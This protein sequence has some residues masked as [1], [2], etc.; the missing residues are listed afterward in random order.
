M[1]ESNKLFQNE[2]KINQS[3]NKR[4]KLIF[5]NNSN[6]KLKGSRGK[7]YTTKLIQSGAN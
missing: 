3:T 5:N 4:I 7:Y 1:R 6:K 2:L